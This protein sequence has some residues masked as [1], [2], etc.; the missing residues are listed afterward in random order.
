MSYVLKHVS[1][2]FLLSSCCSGLLNI[3]QH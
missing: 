3:M 2:L 1:Q